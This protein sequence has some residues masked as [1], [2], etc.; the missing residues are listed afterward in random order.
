MKAQTR[1]NI[2]TIAAA[3]VPMLVAMGYLTDA[4]GQAIIGIITAAMTVGVSLLARRHVG[5]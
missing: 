3:V 5:K 4:M 1:K 2:Y